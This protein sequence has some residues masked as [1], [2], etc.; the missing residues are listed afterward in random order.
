MLAQTIE[1]KKQIAGL[2]KL[3]DKLDILRDAYK[4]ETAY[5]LA[6]GTSF[7]DYSAEYYQEVLKDKLVICVKQ[8]YETLKGITDFH[9][10]NS[11]NYKKYNYSAP[12]PIILFENDP[13]HPDT[14]GL[15]PDLHFPCTNMDN[16]VPRAERLQKRLCASKNFDDYLF[17]DTVGR[18][19]G[20]GI[21]YELGFYL[22]VH[23][24]ISRIV[25][26]GWDI[27]SPGSRLMPHFYK[28]AANQ[29][30][31]NL[32]A[33]MLKDNK[34]INFDDQG[35]KQEA[36]LEGEVD[37]LINVPGYYE[38]EVA[39]IADSTGAAYEWL[40]SHNIE[41]EISSKCSI[42]DSKIPR[43]DLRDRV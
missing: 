13:S 32:P 14:P 21:V 34:L 42:A 9:L 43:V 15:V 29:T 33:N 7:G 3:T 22:A 5:L 23:I 11:W 8:T 10:L 12:E 38:D 28:E 4:G 36:K 24:G 26:V 2:E 40:L 30:F 41:L 20:P 35:K 16:K 19:W 1:L 27:G 18:P 39:M 25:A 6:C 31:S 17:Q 37:S